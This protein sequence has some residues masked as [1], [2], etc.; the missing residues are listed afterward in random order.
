MSKAAASGHSQLISATSVGWSSRK[1]KLL[2]AIPP[3][4]DPCHCNRG[5]HWGSE[6]GAV[7]IIVG[8]L[9]GVSALYR[10]HPQMAQRRLLRTGR[11]H[12]G[13]V[14][15]S[16]ATPVHLWVIFNE[17]DGPPNSSEHDVIPRS[18]DYL[19]PGEQRQ[20]LLQH[21]L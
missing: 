16:P 19:R 13:P 20:E 2:V 12:P 10:Q 5:D 14:R 18:Q 11:R 1:V 4:P 17:D 6:E 21:A 3:L 9:L 8:E 7:D 15:A